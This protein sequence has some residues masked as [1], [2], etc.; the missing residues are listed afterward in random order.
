MVSKKSVY[1]V[2]ISLVILV[3]SRRVEATRDVFIPGANDSFFS[4][5]PFVAN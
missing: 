5:L 1:V 4:F 2:G 3:A